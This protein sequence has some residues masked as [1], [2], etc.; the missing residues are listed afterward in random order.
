MRSNRV[1]DIHK[2]KNAESI[3]HK[4]RIAITLRKQNVKLLRAM[5]AQDVYEKPLAVLSRLQVYIFVALES[6]HR[7]MFGANCS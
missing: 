6:W 3:T 7:L 1:A 5:Q 2:A 4:R